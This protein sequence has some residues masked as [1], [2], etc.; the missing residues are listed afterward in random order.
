MKNILWIIVVIVI[1]GGIWFF[2]GQEIA[3]EQTALTENTNSVTNN[4]AI[5]DEE[6]TQATGGGSYIDYKPEL[7]ARADNGDVVLFFHA[8]WCPTCRLLDNNLIKDY[9]IIPADLTILQVNYD[10]EDD[11]KEKYDIA[12]QHTLV[13]VDSS[14][15]QITKWVGGNDLDS[16]LQ[17]LK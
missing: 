3:D 13:P 14:G 9:E 7:L 1:I 15:D 8:S 2:S 10:K 17:K 5:T 4:P 11:L 6:T 12:Y 16:I